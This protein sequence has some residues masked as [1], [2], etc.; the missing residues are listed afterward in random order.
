MSRVYSLA[1]IAHPVGDGVSESYWLQ[2]IAVGKST[3]YCKFTVAS[4]FICAR[5]GSFLKLPIPP[6]AL[7][8]QKG[9]DD[10]WFGSID[11][12][13]T[14]ES[15]PPID[16][17]ECVEAF[18]DLAAGVIVFDTWVA[19]TDRHGG[20]LSMQ[21]RI[22]KPPELNVFDH[23]HALFSFE[24]PQRLERLRGKFAITEDAESG[25]NRHCLLD[26]LNT[27]DF[28]LKWAQKIRDTP[29]FVVE[30][31]CDMAVEAGILTSTEGASVKGFLV[32]RKAQVF[33]L[34]TQNQHEFK[35]IQS[36]PLL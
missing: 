32:E 17:Q 24:G 6:F 22:G 8:Q 5:L 25:A 7:L 30:D 11:Y 16:P 4:E 27:A 14:G 10:V 29:D 28:F 33:R 1:K 15:L 2:L 34:I 13:L 18:P 23:S 36:W 20:N 12:R 35:A 9:R 3:N 21:N 26:E 19:N 31:T